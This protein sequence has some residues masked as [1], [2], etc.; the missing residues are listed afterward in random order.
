MNKLLIKNRKGLFDYEII[1]KYEAGIMLRGK[2]VKSLKSGRGK[3]EGSYV[4]INNDKPSIINMHIP[5]YQPKNTMGEV[6]PERSRPILLTKKEIKYLTGKLKE[7]KLTLI[8]LKVYLKGRIIKIE[9]GLARGK[10]KIDKRETIKRRESQRD[11]RRELKK[12][13]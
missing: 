3:L 6:D 5:H 13:Y 12:K 4:V 1:E 2:E 9:I 11:I 8:P 10:T 7:K